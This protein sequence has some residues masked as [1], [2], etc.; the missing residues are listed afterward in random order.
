MATKEEKS[1]SRIHNK[2][3]T[4]EIIDRNN[5]SLFDIANVWSPLVVHQIGLLQRFDK[6]PVT[7]I[8]LLKGS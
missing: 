8:L 5:I 7:Q 1:Y 2:R 3:P 4:W 6:E